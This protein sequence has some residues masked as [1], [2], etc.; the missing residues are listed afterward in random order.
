MRPELR[1]LL[2][3]EDLP[4]ALREALAEEGIAAA[5]LP[6]PLAHL[7]LRTEIASHP[8]LLSRTAALQAVG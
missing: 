2:L 8:P 1:A 3:T 4:E 7:A 5:Q 6:A